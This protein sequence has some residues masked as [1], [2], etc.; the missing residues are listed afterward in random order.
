MAKFNYKKWILENKY[1]K[2]EE[3]AIGCGPCGDVN[4]DGVVNSQDATTLMSQVNDDP[5]PIACTQNV[6]NEGFQGILDFIVGNGDLTCA[7]STNTGGQAGPFIGGNPMKGP[8][9]PLAPNQNKKKEKII[10]RVPRSKVR[11]K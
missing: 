5:P 11:R 8:Q 9:G 4:G 3:Q 6:P 7:E 2:L 1:G 10:K